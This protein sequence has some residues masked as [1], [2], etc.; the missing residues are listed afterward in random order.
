MTETE[1]IARNQD[2]WKKLEEM[3]TRENWNPD[4]LIDLFDRV[5]S[6]LSYA[7]TYFANRSVTVY[8]NNL[9]QAVLDKMRIRDKRSNRVSIGTYFSETLPAAVYSARWAFLISFLL[10]A[11]SFLL[12]FLSGL[13][14]PDFP[15]EILG[16]RYVEMTKRNIDADDPMAV[17]KDSQEFDMFL[18]ITANNIKVALVTFV[19]G[20]FA[21]IGTFYVLVINGVMVG[22][23]HAFFV[24]HQSADALAT[25][26]V[27]GTIEISAIII[28]GA[29]G[30]VLG[31]GLLFP[32]T[33]DRLTALRK[34]ARHALVIVSGTLPLFVL[35]GILESFVTRH[36]EIGVGAQGMIALVSLILIVAM[37]IAIPIY[38]YRLGK[39]V[40]WDVPRPS[41]VPAW[42]YNALGHRTMTQNLSVALN[43]YS[44]RARSY[45]S[46]AFLAAM[47]PLLIAGYFL[48]HSFQDLLTADLESHIWYRHPLFVIASWLSLL[49]LLLYWGKHSAQ[50]TNPDSSTSFTISWRQILPL[51]VLCLPLVISILFLP[52]IWQ[53][54]C[55]LVAGPHLLP[56]IACEIFRSDATRIAEIAKKTKTA[57]LSYYRWAVQSFP[58]ILL[59][60][61]SILALLSLSEYVQAFISWHELFN[62]ES[63]EMA[64]LTLVSVVLITG[65]LL[66]S[67]FLHS[68]VVYD[69]EQVVKEASDLRKRLDGFGKR[70]NKMSY[71]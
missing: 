70:L 28:A 66:P 67:F 6:D 8:L 46:T 37:W 4:R 9:T 62:Y 60:A 17:Y 39:R 51:S 48:I 63:Q 27:H 35:A 2:H 7:R 32:E 64:F 10:F 58:M 41:F 40:Q 11:S 31:K 30:I 15:R 13:D 14:N 18:S 53:I 55:Y 12:G 45:F 50:M 44:A 29:A 42:Q 19:F 20:I 16:D 24:N 69:S 21:C 54:V 71:R 43:L 1:F 68:V 61:A 5:S 47:A 26:W 36:T 65:F 56:I 25:V 59:L 49:I 23:F 22:A 3:V 38:A 57:Y 52:L 33:Y 34:S